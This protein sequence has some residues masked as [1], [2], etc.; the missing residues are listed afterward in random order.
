MLRKRSSEQIHVD[1]VKMGIQKVRSGCF[2]CAEGYF[3]LARQH[4]AT[5]EEIRQALDAVAST[6]DKDLSRRELI[7]LIG[8]GG[9]ALSAAGLITHRADAAAAWWGTDSNSQTCCGMPQNFYV[10]RM[11]YGGEP[12]GDGYFFNTSAARAAGG[13]NTFGY[14]GVVGPDS[15][16]SYSPYDW[17]RKQ[18][19]NAWNAWYN[20]PN[21]AF[22]W[23]YTVF[24][25][26]ESGFGGWSNGNYGPN[27][28]VLNGFC[29]ELYNITPANPVVWP[30]IYISPYTWGQFFGTGF[31]TNTAFV[32]WLAGCDTCGSD[33]CNP[34]NSSCNTLTTVQ[35]R[36]SSTVVNIGLGGMKPVLWQYWISDCGCGDYNVAI[37]HTNSFGVVT[38]GSRYS[39]C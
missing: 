32:L 35:N 39:T 31:R 34:C 10:G 20:S 5:D 15:R 12:G 23:G 16:G 7:K 22:I 14:W 21:H 9:L 36:L 1:A 25:D 28:A 3:E 4:G 24:G 26:V 2:S 27:Q 30:G 37:Q 6:P 33:I 29:T 11:G 19:D 17:G 18:A 13:A 8:A 38:G